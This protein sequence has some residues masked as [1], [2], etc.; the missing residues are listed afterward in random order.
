MA[1]STKHIKDALQTLMGT[2]PNVTVYQ[3][4]VPEDTVLPVTPGGKIRPYIVLYFSEPF[5]AAYGRGIVSTRH[6]VNVLVATVQV[7]SP[8][9]HSANSII[10]QVRDKIVGWQTTD[11]GE[12]MLRGGASRSVGNTSVAPTLYIREAV[13]ETRCNL[14]FN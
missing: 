10:D 4:Q 7:N 14:S 2:I 9:P 1:Q 6:D 12:W 11:T 8:D 3:D 5:R 13:F